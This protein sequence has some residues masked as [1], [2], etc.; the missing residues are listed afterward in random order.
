[1][2][3][4]ISLDTT[5][6]YLQP[7]EGWEDRKDRRSREREAIR[8]LI[9][10]VFGGL[11]SLDHDIHGAPLLIAANGCTEKPPRIS[12]SHGA[13]MAVLA[14]SHDGRRIGVDIE[15]Q[16]EQLRRVAPRF[17]S[18]GEY[19]RFA[20]SDMLILKAWTAKEALFKAVGIAGLTICD[21]LL[22]ADF[23]TS[24]VALGENN[25]D[26]RSIERG[27]AVLTLARENRF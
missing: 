22:P 3:Q 27:D 15:R 18:A 11:Y 12:I 24:S 25:Y 6:I 23:E 26:V 17:L 20:S 9:D 13:A 4:T 19:D 7:I 21:I 16:S 8:T 14:V 1:M 5:T 2:M 10:R